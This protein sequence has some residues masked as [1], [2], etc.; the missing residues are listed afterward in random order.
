M[1]PGNLLLAREARLL[2]PLLLVTLLCSLSGLA[3]YLFRSAAWWSQLNTLGHVGSGIFFVILLFP[4][5]ARHFRRTLGIRRPLMILSGFVVVGVMLASVY[6]G[7]HLAI[8]GHREDAVLILDLHW[9]GSFVLLGL[10]LLHLALHRLVRSRKQ[11]GLYHSLG[12]LRLTPW[13]TAVGGYLLAVALLH[14]LYSWYHDR[15]ALEQTVTDY[16]YDYGEHPFRPSQTETPGSEFLATAEVAGSASCA[17]CHADIAAQWRSSAHRQAASDAAYVTNVT[18]LENNKGISATRY[19]EG[20]HAPIALLTGQLTPGGEHGGIGDTPAN[21]EGVSCLGCHRIT[22]AVHLEGVASYHYAPASE[23]LFQHAENGALAK[24]NRFLIAAS[25]AQHKADMAAPILSE[26]THCATCHTQFMDKDMNDWGWVKMQ[27]DYQAWLNSPYSRQHQQ[28]FANATVVRCQD[29]HMPLVAA[30]DPSADPNGKVRSHRFLAANTMLPL[31]A[32]DRL[33]LEATIEFLR[34]NKMTI[35]IEP[36]N[37]EQATQ[38]K[39][40]L[41]ET[42]RQPQ[43]TPDYHYLG[44]TVEL[45]VIV[46]NSGVGH[47][48]PGGT[49]DINE[50]WVD[51]EVS[52]AEG[53]LIYRSGEIGAADELDPQAHRYLSIP[54]NREGKAVWR[55]DLFNMTGETYRNVIKSG[56]SDVVDYA[57]EIP[58][59]AK[60][61]IVVNARLRYR[62]L[63][64]RYA[65]W[66]L[67]E[68]YRK[69]PIVDMAHDNIVIELRQEPEVHDRQQRP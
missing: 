63:N 61:P 34:S 25:A 39:L 24:L 4:Y 21:R 44:E 54:V 29:C 40:H 56:G 43:E 18:L 35:T 32:G 26:P 67:K 33:Q 68:N 7:L 1:K 62:K 58:Y 45:S 15:P 31:L 37:R 19:C 48:F 38:S 9:Y 3:A 13:L 5:V 52:D 12:Y 22:H 50:A 11:D 59:W 57:F 55:H 10:L 28:H 14:A 66:A 16:Q 46:G 42:L 6:S 8:V 47:D 53:R 2:Q 51:L 36:P 17:R 41:D 20:C 60:G 30:D 69:L 23:Y 65:R 49:I 64:A 27:D